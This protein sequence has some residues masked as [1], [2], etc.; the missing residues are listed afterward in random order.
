MGLL[1]K[2][3]IVESESPIQGPDKTCPRTRGK[4]SPFFPPHPPLLMGLLLMRK[5]TPLG[6]Q[7][8]F[9]SALSTGTRATRE[10]AP[11]PEPTLS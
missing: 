9:M 5:G 7:L 2:H 11:A 6:P 4:R 3:D 1:S 8:H 10:A